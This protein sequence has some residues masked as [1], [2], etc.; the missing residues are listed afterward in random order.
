MGGAWER[1]VRSIKSAMLEAYSENLD[2]ERLITLLVEAESI[3]N[4]RPLTY[5]PLNSAELEALTPNHLLLGS[6]S[7]VH[8]PEVKGIC[9][10]KL[11]SHSWDLLQNQLNSFWRRWTRE[12][13]PTLTKRTKWFE[14]TRNIEVGDLVILIEDSRRNGWTRGRIL[15]V[16][17]AADGRVRQAIVQLST[18]GICRRPA[19]KL[20]VLE[21]QG[22]SG[23]DSGFHRGEDVAARVLTDSTAAPTVTIINDDSGDDSGA[24]PERAGKDTNM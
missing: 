24:I 13:L 4:S 20:A 7:G 11:L 15:E 5:L 19:S 21:V 2:D 6:S 22:G 8:Q 3:V 9:D 1:M 23:T 18:G 12:Y 14:D 17:S 10:T 16:I